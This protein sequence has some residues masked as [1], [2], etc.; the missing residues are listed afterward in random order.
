MMMWYA[1]ESQNQTGA[2][3]GTKLRQMNPEQTSCKN[4]NMLKQDGQP[5][6]PLSRVFSRAA[7]RSR[8]S[9]SLRK[10]RARTSSG[11]SCV[12]CLRSGT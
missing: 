2:C 7:A 11:A 6:G 5:L 8:S 9:S 10:S 1:L 12:G 4:E 3:V